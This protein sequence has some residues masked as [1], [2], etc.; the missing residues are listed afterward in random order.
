MCRFLLASLGI[1]AVLGGITIGQRRKILKE[2]AQGNGLSDAYTATLTRLK[3]QRGNM[4]GLGLQA[5]MWVSSSQRP[6]RAEELCHALGVEIGSSELDPENI[7]ALRT[8]LASCLGL[9]V[10]GHLRP[11]S[12]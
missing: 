9:L 10:V 8:L 12:D 7:P 6:L 2:M 3:A 4:V 1:E 5:L 11:Q